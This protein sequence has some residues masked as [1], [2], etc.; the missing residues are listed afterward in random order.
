[1]TDF[2]ICL[3]DGEEW[4]CCPNCYHA[5]PAQEILLELVYE[6]S[7]FDEAPHWDVV[8]MKCRECGTKYN[9]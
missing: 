6:N 9:L 8:A 2:P 7:G 4:E 3:I 5:D 1:M